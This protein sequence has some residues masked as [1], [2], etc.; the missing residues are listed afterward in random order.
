MKTNLLQVIIIATAFSSLQIHTM[1]N[2]LAL[3]Q[4][5]QYYLAQQSSRNN[6][7]VTVPP[8]TADRPIYLKNNNSKITQQTRTV[9]PIND[10]NIPFKEDESLTLTQPN[11]HHETIILIQQPQFIEIDDNTLLVN[12][13]DNIVLTGNTIPINCYNKVICG[14]AAAA[15]LLCAACC[16]TTFV[17]GVIAAINL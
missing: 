13:N 3:Q 1:D 7:T 6:K 17:I 14:K 10:T 5:Q 16:F 9:M 12:C 4:V 8:T 2:P 15:K 11:K